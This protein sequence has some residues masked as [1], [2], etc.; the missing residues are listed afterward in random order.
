MYLT[1]KSKSPVQGMNHSMR[2]KAAVI[3]KHMGM[4]RVAYEIPS[5]S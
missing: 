5:F 4:A 3:P 1:S 2:N